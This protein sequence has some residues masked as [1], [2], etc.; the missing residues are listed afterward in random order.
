MWSDAGKKQEDGTGGFNL[1]LYWAVCKQKP[2]ASYIILNI[3]LGCALRPVCTNFEP[4]CCAHRDV[5]I[6]VH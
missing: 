5:L 2:V 1:K 3:L 6:V 4:S